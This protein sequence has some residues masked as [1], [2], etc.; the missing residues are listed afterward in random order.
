MLPDVTRR[1][2]RILD[3]TD[4]GDAWNHGEDPKLYPIDTGRLRQVIE[5]A[6]AGS[7]GNGACCR[8]TGSASR[9]TTAS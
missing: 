9:A 4:L 2:A 5:T 7:A 6:A 1:I 3:P 8:A